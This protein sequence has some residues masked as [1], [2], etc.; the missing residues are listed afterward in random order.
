MEREREL[1]HDVCGGS[2]H[3]AIEMA[4]SFRALLIGTGVKF[5]QSRMLHRVACLFPDPHNVLRTRGRRLLPTVSPHWKP[6]DRVELMMG[7]EAARKRVCSTTEPAEIH[8]KS[9]AL[10][11]ISVEGNIGRD[12]AKNI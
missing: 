10:T 8:S 9:Q 7:T 5:P 1:Q 2:E 3:R 4:L 6:G 12:S 11:R